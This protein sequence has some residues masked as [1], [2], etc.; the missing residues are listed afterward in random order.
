MFN[1]KKKLNIKL[2]DLLTN[3]VSN[4]SPHILSIVFSI[5]DDMEIKTHIPN[6]NKTLTLHLKI[7][8]LE[9]LID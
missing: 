4:I 9:T 6:V 7:S 3:I 5:T 2:N 1:I 8:K